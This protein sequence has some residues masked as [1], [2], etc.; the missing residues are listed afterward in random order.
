MAK[1]SNP[2]R[3]DDKDEV[4][5]VEETKAI[6]PPLP[7]VNNVRNGQVPVESEREREMERERET[8]KGE[9]A[10]AIRDDH[11]RLFLKGAEGGLRCRKIERERGGI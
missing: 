10:M 1:W 2:C 6:K 11:L 9:K 3:T 5:K 7:S 8:D 4:H